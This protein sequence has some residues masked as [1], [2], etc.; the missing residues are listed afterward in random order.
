MGESTTIRITASTKRLLES[1][2][3]AGRRLDPTL[4]QQDIVQ[5]ALAIA[6]RH[7][8]ELL[9]DKPVATRAQVRARLEGIAGDYGDLSG[10]VD[11]LVYGD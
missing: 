4:T 7:R 3:A 10:N 8:D 1:L 5:R 6:S 11:S 9:E 2:H